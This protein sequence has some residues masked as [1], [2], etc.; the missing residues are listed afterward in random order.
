MAL[1]APHSPID[2][3]AL[4]HA[5]LVMQAMLVD[6]QVVPLLGAGVNV[7]GRPENESWL[8]GRYLP[9]GREL[10]AVLA[11]KV[12]DYPPTVLED[13]L[14]VSQCVDLKRGW[15]SLYGMLHELFDDD[16]PATE[17]HR[18]LADV[19]ALMAALPR[20]PRDSHLL[21]VTTNYDDVLERAFEE[22]GEPYDLVWYVA[23]G[24]HVGKF[25][26]RP[27]G[28]EPVVV[29]DPDQ[30]VG[31]LDLA[32]RSV[33]LKIHG[34]VDRAGG[35][36]DSYVIT[37]NNYIEYLTRTDIRRLIP[38]GLAAKLRSSSILF[39]GYSLRD[40]NLRAI[41]HR[42]WQEERLGWKSWAIRRP[43]GAL[44][45]ELAAD[46]AAPELH[47]QRELEG[48]LEESFWDERGVDIFDVDLAVYTDALKHAA[49]ELVGEPGAP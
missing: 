24:D 36:N 12:P 30:Y 21:V 13:L 37:E 14:R 47:R 23:R 40:W 4:A 38:R 33:I 32:Q 2:P 28:E 22:A 15:R 10:A 18:F 11:R 41:F 46:P 1:A 39:L 27:L 31:P 20:P 44:P 9:D 17:L 7:C 5:R 6:G 49:L 34:A 25:M 43:L 48:E 16:Y 42:I 29:E 35:E 8:Q 3:R 45:A 26:H 19:P